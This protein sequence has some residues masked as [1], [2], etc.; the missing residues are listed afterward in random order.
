MTFIFTSLDKEA[1]EAA[2]KYIRALTARHTD[3][4]SVLATGTSSL[5]MLCKLLKT[6]QNHM[7]LKL[8]VLKQPEWEQRDRIEREMFAFAVND[9]IG[10]EGG[11]LEYIDGYMSYAEDRAKGGQR[12]ERRAKVRK[13][14]AKSDNGKVVKTRNFNEKKMTKRELDAL[15]RAVDQATGTLQMTTLSQSKETEG[16]IDVDMDT[17]D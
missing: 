1:G 14:A 3:N 17:A 5:G 8:D 11:Y 2:W 12:L 4:Y 6:V 13:P 9:M 7:H 15:E 16:G 10:W